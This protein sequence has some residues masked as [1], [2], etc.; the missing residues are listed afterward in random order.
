MSTPLTGQVA[1]VTG[2]GR[3]IGRACALHLA[4]LGARVA[5]SDLNLN[6][7]AEFGEKLSA[8][9]VVDECLAYGT[10]ATGIE[11]DLTMRNEAEDAVR[12]TVAVLGGLDILVNCA[13]GTAAS[14]G[15][16]PQDEGG[17]Q[18]LDTRASR[19]PEDHYRQQLS[20]NLT[21]TVFTCQA[22][23]AVMRERGR[24]RIVNI[25]SQAATRVHPSGRLAAYSIAKAA[26]SHYTRVLAAEL[27]PDGIRVNAI[28]PG[29][30]V[31]HRT[32]VQLGSGFESWRD[33][34]AAHVPL[35]RIGTPED[36]AKVTE[37]LVS[38][39]SAY[40]T[41]QVITVCGGGSLSGV[42]RA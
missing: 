6:S 3:G 15:N 11:A 25:S 27:G 8:P 34:T 14:P 32:V 9:T 7:A 5:V 38:E 23:A 20:G 17:S 26:T 1:L 16:A 37:F 4:R 2:A 28:A 39:Q 22:A 42:D 29:F 12:T 21:T 30:I 40:I 19:M 41:G 13:G 31:T 10:E 36:V 33:A 24:G 35:R 18:P